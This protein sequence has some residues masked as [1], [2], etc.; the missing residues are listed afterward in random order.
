MRHSVSESHKLVLV[1]PPPPPV[2]SPL[3]KLLLA[4]LQSST[5]LAVVVEGP[6]ISIPSEQFPII[7]NI[8]HRQ[9]K[10]RTTLLVKIMLFENYVLKPYNNLPFVFRQVLIKVVHREGYFL[11]CFQLLLQKTS[12][13]F[14]MFYPSKN[15]C[16]T[17]D[18]Y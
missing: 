10:A 16:I 4:S 18:H 9:M 14:Q 12:S 6:E 2:V 1:G 15:P 13:G 3:L 17:H 7:W 5:E 11:S 8:K